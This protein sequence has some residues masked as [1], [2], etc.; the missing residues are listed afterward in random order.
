[1]RCFSQSVFHDFVIKYRWLLLL[2]GAL[3]MGLVVIF[4]QV[5]VLQWVVLIPALWVIFLRLQ[6]KSVSY[7]TLYEM[8]FCFFLVYFTVTFHWFLWMYPLDYAG[9]SNL[10]SAVVVCLGSLGLATFQAAGAA[11][12]FPLFALSIR[13]NALSKRPLLHPLL[14]ATMWVILEWWQAHSGWSGVPW[15]RLAIGQ[16]DVLVTMQSASLF[17]SYF[18]SF[19]ILLVNGYVA[20]AF[21]HINKRIFCGVMTLSLTLGNLAFGLIY[22]AI[23]HQNVP[24][25][26]VA[27]IQGNL[28]SGDEWGALGAVDRAM[29]TY[30]KL[31]KEAAQAGAELVLWPETAIVVN[32]DRSR[33]IRQRIQALAQ[34]CGVM[35]LAGV[36]TDSPEEGD[37]NAIVTVRPDGSIDEAVYA[38]RNLVPFGEFVPFR[39]LITTLIPP[40]TEINTLGSDLVMG[41]TALAIP[42]ESG[43]GYVSPLICFDSIYENNALESVHK[44]ANLLAVPTND[45]WFKDSRGVWMHSAQGQ[46]RAI[47]TGRYVM[48]AANTGVSSVITDKGKVLEKLDPFATGYVLQEAK[49]LSHT[50]LYTVIGNL[51]VYLCIGFAGGCVLIPVGERY[52]KKKTCSGPLSDT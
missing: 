48:R 12:I 8:G 21:L 47:E 44:G 7:W 36:F 23:P 26:K 34:E 19:L 31:T 50:T 43:I 45:S 16:A 5:G 29:D 10:A 41:D 46:L 11:I 13:S 27:S 3:L 33:S 18:V 35:I 42:L 22:T 30:E 14:F 28:A 1:M 6:D 37:Y 17:G 40:L 49:L 39:E 20:Y 9:M 24:S 4:P 25:I 38:K 15:G 32:I 2:V 51:F 52:R